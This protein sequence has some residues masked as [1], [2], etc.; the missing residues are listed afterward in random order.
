MIEQMLRKAVLSRSLVEFQYQGG[1]KVLEP[2]IVA[3]NMQ[4]HILLHGWVV[5]G[6]RKFGEEGFQD[7]MLAGISGLK[8]LPETFFQARYGYNPFNDRKFANIQFC[9]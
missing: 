2:H 3:H 4:G 9:L 5:Q 7:Y 6:D 1:T 8:I